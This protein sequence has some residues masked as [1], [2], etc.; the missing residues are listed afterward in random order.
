MSYPSV[1]HV[2]GT[3]HCFVLCV[4]D[5][6]CFNPDGPISMSEKATY[7]NLALLFAGVTLVFALAGTV[8]LQPAQLEFQETAEVSKLPTG[9]YMEH[10]VFESDGSPRSR[11]SLNG[12][13]STR[14]ELRALIDKYMLHSSSELAVTEELEGGRIFVIQL[15]WRDHPDQLLTTFRIYRKGDAGPPIAYLCMVH[16]CIP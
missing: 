11:I 1:F 6:P 7:K 13:E 15:F 8:M 2:S 9:V 4:Q 16:E 10:I 3:G 14:V 12:I 5:R